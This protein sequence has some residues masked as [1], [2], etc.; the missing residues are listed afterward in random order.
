MSLVITH[1]ET[2]RRFFAVI[3]G[4]ESSVEYDIQEQSPRVIDIYRTFVHP[5]MRGR[6]IAE[7]LLEAVGEF[8]E[9][10]AL[11]IMPS[12]SYAVIYYRRHPDKAEILAP[13]VDLKNSGSCRIRQSPEQGGADNP[14]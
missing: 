12:C 8:A 14:A 7:A 13:G 11:S 9:S 1:D 5:D 2:R 10:K 3:D 6:G 4:K